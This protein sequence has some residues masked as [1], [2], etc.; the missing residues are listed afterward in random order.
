[1]R[2][3]VSAS[4]HFFFACSLLFSLADVL[5]W[6]QKVDPAQLKSSNVRHIDIYSDEFA[7]RYVEKVI[8]R[9]NEN[10]SALF[11]GGFVVEQKLY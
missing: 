1:M 6:Y 7:R 3:C 11:R 5:F 2:F 8:I 9:D 10:I 4:S